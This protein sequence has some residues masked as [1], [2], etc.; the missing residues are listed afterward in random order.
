M[1]REGCQR[2]SLIPEN[3]LAEPALNARLADSSALVRLFV[4]LMSDRRRR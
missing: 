3:P 2:V 4:R 1:L